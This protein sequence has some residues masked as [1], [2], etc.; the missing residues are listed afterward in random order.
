MHVMRPV[1][2]H[3]ADGALRPTTPLQ[4]R[5]GERVGII[6]IRCPDTTRWDLARIGQTALEDATLAETGLDE[7]LR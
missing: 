6:V 7:L 5:P 1:E 3:Y 4:L 2:A